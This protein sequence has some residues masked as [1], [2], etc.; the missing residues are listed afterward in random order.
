MS[1]N[2]VD[3]EID[4][5]SIVKFTLTRKE[6]MT[7]KHDLTAIHR[8]REMD[9]NKYTPKNGRYKSKTGPIKFLRITEIVSN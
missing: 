8:K 3:D 5:Y 4:P 6:F 1:E 2:T 9:R 7:L